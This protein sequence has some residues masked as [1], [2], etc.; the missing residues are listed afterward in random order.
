MWEMDLLLFVKG[1]M[2]SQVWRT[3]GKEPRAW[4][5]TAWIKIPAP[6]PTSL[7]DLGKWPQL[8]TFSYSIFDSRTGCDMEGREMARFGAGTAQVGQ[9]VW[10]Q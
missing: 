1:R 9:R 6:P 7:V 8:P 4:N 3:Y 2:S 5:W 10:M